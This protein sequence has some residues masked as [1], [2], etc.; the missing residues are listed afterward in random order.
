MNLKE[1]YQSHKNKCIKNAS[2]IEAAIN[3]ITNLKEA[4]NLVMTGTE[5]SKQDFVRNKLGEFELPKG[6]L[7]RNTHGNAHVCRFDSLGH[8]EY[9]YIS[10]SAKQYVREKEGFED[11]DTYWILSISQLK[12]IN[13]TYILVTD[14]GLYTADPKQ[15]KH[16]RRT[17][18][19]PKKDWIPLNNV[20]EKTYMDFTYLQM[21]DP[22]KNERVTGKFA[23]TFVLPS[24]NELY[25][26][27]TSKRDLYKRIFESEEFRQIDAISYNTFGYHFNKGTDWVIE[28]GDK[29]II[30][31]FFQ[32]VAEKKTKCTKKVKSL[33]EIEQELEEFEK[34]N[35]LLYTE[36]VAYDKETID[37]YLKR[38]PEDLRTIRS[39]RNYL[40]NPALWNS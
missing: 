39:L 11:E 35:E 24:G 27:G 12:N 10:F 7:N 4:V 37:R 1:S 36:C 14:D 21:V 20:E 40:R 9:Y 15:F 3:Q 26:S 5:P 6:T 30:A 17:A 34:E 13:L 28:S 8:T 16:N 22:S 33:G 23:V 2:R 18:S 19:L 32:S 29:R 38:V 31:K 25:Y